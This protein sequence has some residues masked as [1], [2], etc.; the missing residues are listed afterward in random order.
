M[1][2]L[3]CLVDNSVFYNG[4]DSK[5]L[6]RLTPKPKFKTSEVEFCHKWLRSNGWKGIGQPIICLHVRDSGY[7]EEYGGFNDNDISF[8]NYHSYRDSEIIDYKKAV[9]WLLSEPQ[10]AFVVRA[11]KSANQRLNISSDQLVDYPFSKDK[12]DLI[13]I[14]LFSNSDMVISTGSGP[15]V[16]SSIF[17]VPTIYLNHLVLSDSYSWSKSLWS[18][19]HLYWIHS[20]KHLTFE[21]YALANYHKTKD[22]FNYGIEIKN[23]TPDEILNIVKDGWTYFIDNKPIKDDDIAVTDRVRGIFKNN[24]IIQSD[25]Q[26]IN[27]EWVISSSWIPD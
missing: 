12:N 1:P 23:L 2:Y 14:W 16:I 4:R 27:P 24:K 8:W 20:G 9:E 13:D 17:Q 11:G 15:D 6:T 19:K 10:S 18:S 5:G 22:Y 25:N 21:E 3:D 7:L 26:W